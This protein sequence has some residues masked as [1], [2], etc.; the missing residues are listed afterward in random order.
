M[1]YVESI[2]KHKKVYITLMAIITVVIMY[3][4]S[5]QFWKNIRLAGWLDYMLM[6]GMFLIF[7]NAGINLRIWE[8]EK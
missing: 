5:T 3:N 4:E 8:D 1:V 7:I 6:I 2:R